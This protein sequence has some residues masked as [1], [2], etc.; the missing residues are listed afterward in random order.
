LHIFPNPVSAKCTVQTPSHSGTLALYSAT[1]ILLQ[2]WPDCPEQVEVNMP[3]VV[4][5]L[6]YFRWNKGK[7]VVLAPVVIGQ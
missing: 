3:G 1:G 5:G 7:D 2:I 6:Y 4:N